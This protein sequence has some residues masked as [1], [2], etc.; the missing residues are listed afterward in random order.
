[1]VFGQDRAE[2]RAGVFGIQVELPRH[3]RLVTD[4][5]AAEVQLPVHPEALCLQGP[6]DDLA[7]QDLLGEILRSDSHGSV[8]APATG[9]CR[10]Q[11]RE[12]G[13]PLQASLH[14]DWRRSRSPRS[15]SAAR[16][17][18]AAGTAPARIWRLSTI[19]MP[20]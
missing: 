12:Q 4:E 3:E 7:Q 5:G 9:P 6:R 13:Q 18:R 17:R 14:F 2:A 8:L 16:A 1:R 10:E 20:R 15:A 19:A 11:R